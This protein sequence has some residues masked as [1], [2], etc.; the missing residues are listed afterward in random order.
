MNKIVCDVCGSTYSE[1]EAQ[2]PICGTAKSDE[3]KPTVE[4]TVDKSAGNG[5][6]FARANTRRGDSADTKKGGQNKKQPA[7]QQAA[8]SN[9]AMI[10]IVGV[11][12]LAI[13]GV[14]VFLFTG[15]GGNEDDTTA[16][17]STTQPTQLQIPCTG[18]E[19][20]DS[21]QNSLAFTE[22]TQAAQLTV[23]P[24]PA[25]TTDFVT[26]TYSSSD[27]TVAQVDANGVVTPMGNGTATITVAY[28]SY[29]ITVN[30]TCNVPKPITGLKLSKSEISFNPNT[31]TTWTW[32][33]A[34]TGLLEDGTSTNLDAA[35]IV[36]TSSDEA[37]A[38]VENGVVTALSNGNA[39]ITAA[40]GD[41]TATCKIIVRD[42][43][44]Q[45]NFELACTWGVKNDA[46]MVE[47][48]KI[49]I[50]LLNKETNQPVAGLE[51]TPSNDFKNGCASFVV[52]EKGIEVTALKTTDN[53]SGQYVYI[54]TVYEGV[55][56]RFIIRIKPAANQ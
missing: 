28:G 34:A 6:K 29:T 54:Q 4:A 40:Y 16:P 43:D 39:V 52:T 22:L 15:L 17:S 44:V 10:I 30:V 18:I 3:G 47:G 9:L 27:P 55:Q 7:D 53:V 56:Y 38:Q 45:T 32:T 42:M 35:D 20:V 24:I 37:V 33:I 51:W 1:T 8:P 50:F 19:L 23:Q 13:V 46:T 12:L 14:C 11:L 49:E 2:C 36:W 31:T 25:D 48:E 26:Y 21:A 5:G 41:L